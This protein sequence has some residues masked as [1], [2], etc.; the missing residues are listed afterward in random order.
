M[1]L[2]AWLIGS[3]KRKHDEDSDS[4]DDC[5]TTPEKKSNLVFQDKWLQEFDWLRHDTGKDVIFC[6]P[7]RE[8]N[9]GS[10]SNKTG[11]TP[12]A[13]AVGTKGFRHWALIKHQKTGDHKDAT[14]TKNR[15]GDL[16]QAT[17]NV[18][19]IGATALFAQIGAAMLLAKEDIAGTQFH[20]L[21]HAQVSSITIVLLVLLIGVTSFERFIGSVNQISL[22][23]LKVYCLCT[24]HIRHSKL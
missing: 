20:T 7:C 6:Q 8:A 2:K 17:Q 5:S 23:S 21:V 24:F 10:R 15:R 22:F 12:N 4:E 3:S 1:S 9:I 14:K 19:S 16:Q 11:G 18:Q 13:F